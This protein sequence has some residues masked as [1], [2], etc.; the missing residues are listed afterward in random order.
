MLGWRY[1]TTR[2]AYVHRLRGGRRG[3]VFAPPG[4]A[5]D[6]LDA[7]DDHL[8]DAI[9]AALDA[10]RDLAL[11][12]AP[13]R[14]EA[15]GRATRVAEPDPVPAPAPAE[16]VA[17]TGAGDPPPLARRTPRRAEGIASPAPVEVHLDGELRTVTVDG[18]PPRAPGR[19]HLAIAAPDDASNGQAEATA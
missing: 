11:S 18:R 3:P 5:F 17:T 8:A 19:P 4:A 16:R 15:S 6:A 12:G 10:P 7:H 9:R 2:E 13:R 1:S 14:A